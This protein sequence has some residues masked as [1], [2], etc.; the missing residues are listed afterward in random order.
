MR[1]LTAHDANSFPELLS[2]ERLLAVNEVYLV[3]S[4]APSDVTTTGVLIE[5]ARSVKDPVTGITFLL[6]TIWLVGTMAELTLD[7]E[8]VLLVT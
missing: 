1:R 3:P 8:A 4:P 6:L 5:H 2:G 7:P